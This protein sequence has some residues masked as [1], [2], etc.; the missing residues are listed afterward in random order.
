MARLER[1]ELP[2]AGF[3]DQNSIQLSYRRMIYFST[4]S[5]WSEEKDLNLHTPLLMAMGLGRFKRSSYLVESVG[6]EPATVGL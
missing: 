2:T 4:F 6:L 5:C 1:L 3:E